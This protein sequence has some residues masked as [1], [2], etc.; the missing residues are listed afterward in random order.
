MLHLALLKPFPILEKNYLCTI[1]YKASSGE[2]EC[3]FKIETEHHCLFWKRENNLQFPTL[4]QH[5]IWQLPLSSLPYYPPPLA[6]LLLQNLSKV[7]CSICQK[8]FQ[9]H[10]NMFKN[11]NTLLPTTP[12]YTAEKVQYRRCQRYFQ[13][14]SKYIRNSMP[15]LTITPC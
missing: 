4:A 12:C 5:P 3:L 8:Y 11:I 6:T 1:C 14:H 9:K 7:Q 15:Y 13:K 10:S 2:Y